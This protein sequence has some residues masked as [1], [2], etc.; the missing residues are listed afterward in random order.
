MG[1]T[2]SASLRLVRLC[3]FVFD[4]LFWGGADLRAGT[5]VLVI[6]GTGVAATACWSRPTA[7]LP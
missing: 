3:V 4:T 5:R 6:C 2:S 1:Q 7:A